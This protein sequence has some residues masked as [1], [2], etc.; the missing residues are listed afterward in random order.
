MIETKDLK[1]LEKRIVMENRKIERLRKSVHIFEV[2]LFDFQFGIF[3]FCLKKTNK[4]V[5]QHL[6]FQD[7]DEIELV[8]HFG[9]TEELL[10]RTHNRLTKEQLQVSLKLS[11]K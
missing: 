3:I 4:P 5:N 8:E 6:I 2:N 7:E 1:W 9:T 11:I 10:K